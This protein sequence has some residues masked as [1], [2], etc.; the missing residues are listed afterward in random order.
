MATQGPLVLVLASILVLIIRG[1]LIA[2]Q[3]H[4]ALVAALMKS[5]DDRVIAERANTT[6]ERE[7]TQE[8]KE[9]AQ[10]N[11]VANEKQ[12]EVLRAQMTVISKVA[13]GAS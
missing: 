10:R 5:A 4:D 11:I 9:I 1:E 12:A 2:K 3:N 7:R 6:S 13:E 8:W